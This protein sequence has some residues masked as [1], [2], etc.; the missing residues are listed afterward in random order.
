MKRSVPARLVAVQLAIL[1]ALILS[2]CQT[3]PKT[4][5]AEGDTPTY[6]EERL[7]SVSGRSFGN[8]SAAEVQT[9]IAKYRRPE[10]MALGGSVFNGVSS[11]QINW[12]LAQWSPPAQVARALGGGNLQSE[13]PGFKTAHYKD[14]GAD[15]YG[16][17]ASG[18]PTFRMGMDLEITGVSG[19][20]EA[21]RHQAFVM[22][23]FETYRAEDG[24]YFNDNLGFGG[25]AIEDIL[26]GTATSYRQQLD[27]RPAPK[28]V[29][30]PTPSYRE[31][32]DEAKAT[33]N[34]LEAGRK[35]GPLIKTFYAVNSA[36]V[37]DPL[38]HECVSEMT[39]L[40]Q[41]MLRQPKRLLVGVGSNSG[42]FTFLIKG[43]DLQDV[44]ADTSFNFSSPVQQVTRQV[45][46]ART[47]NREF[48]DNMGKMLDRLASS[49]NRGIENIY[50]LGQ[51]RPSSI[52]NLKPVGSQK[53]PGP[54]NYYDKYELD[55]STERTR[56]ISGHAVRAVDQLNTTVN[57]ELRA[58]VEAHNR[59][60][61]PR[62][63]FVDLEAL[64]DKLDFK[65]S[66][67]PQ[68]QV[69]V[70][71]E[72]LPGLREGEEV[73]LDNRTLGF[74]RAPLVLSNGTVAGQKIE[75][76]GIFSVDNLHPTVVGYSKLANAMLDEI[77]KEEKIAIAPDGRTAIDPRA[78]YARHEA[79]DGNILRHPDRY[80]KHREDW[81]QALV[82]LVPARDD[83]GRVEQE[84]GK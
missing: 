69:V 73:R 33:K 60:K 35:T 24:Q 37:L 68:H 74:S 43:Q 76:G 40:D 32:R 4:E 46:I 19:L 25:A 71:R 28:K 5:R 49:E 15:P 58:M 63:V 23:D 75:Q 70:T 10:M 14:F 21:I 1:G 55:F 6:P 67:D 3:T 34:L 27:V 45:S 44:C 79:Y 20:T 82:N 29:G 48:L 11:L 52:A 66:G 38:H 61:G 22:S 30:D 56:V 26:Y 59:T 57:R 64:S 9:L 53:P 17:T 78:L 80:L 54:G 83:C 2:S 16:K 51:L 72:F 18:Q 36:F 42:L 50:V 13:I 41:V 62:F 47:A 77:E 12:W 65:H 81:L 8:C 39:A 84:S 7:A 31:M